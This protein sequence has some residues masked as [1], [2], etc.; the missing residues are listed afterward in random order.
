MIADIY[1]CP[2]CGCNV[3]LAQDEDECPLCN[4]GNRNNMEP[5]ELGVDLQFDKD[6]GECSR[7]AN[8]KH[9]AE[10]LRIPYGDRSGL[11]LMDCWKYA[12]NPELVDSA[13][14]DKV[15]DFINDPNGTL[16]GKHKEPMD[17]KTLKKEV[18]RL[19]RLA[20][21]KAK[22]PRDYDEVHKFLSNPFSY[23]PEIH[24]YVK[25]DLTEVKAEACYK[26]KPSYRIDNYVPVEKDKL[27]PLSKNGYKMFSCCYVSS[28]TT[29][30]QRERQMPKWINKAS[31]KIA[32]HCVQP[33]TFS[34]K[35][36][37]F[38]SKLTLPT[39]CKEL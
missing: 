20:L 4:D 11:Y 6:C 36:N 7:Y 37:R 9:M 5:V 26:S 17:Y 29:P 16:Q 21:G 13:N 14:I 30:E 24:I 15:V 32:R 22:M 33:N 3:Y 8:F 23:N 31:R 18:K 1:K 39:E 34:D 19:L 28:V 10:L 12:W 25:K 38:L 27:P 35:I 2:Y